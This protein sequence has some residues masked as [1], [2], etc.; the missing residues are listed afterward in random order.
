M[1]SGI[2][3]EGNQIAQEQADEVYKRESDLSA[4]E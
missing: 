4:K 2:V 1:G 3:F